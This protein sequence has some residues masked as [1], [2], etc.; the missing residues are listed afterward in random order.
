MRANN[1]VFA[2]DSFARRTNL[3]FASLLIIT[4]YLHVGKT[5]PFPSFTIF[6]LCRVKILVGFLIFEQLC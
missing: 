1:L 2:L 4:E 3:N 6:R 5:I